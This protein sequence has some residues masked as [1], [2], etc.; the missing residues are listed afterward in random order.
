MQLTDISA[1]VL[2]P[3]SATAL[4]ALKELLTLPMLA[5]VP[6][7]PDKFTTERS[8]EISTQLVISQSV[9]G[10][11]FVTDNVA[12]M[13][14]VWNFSGYIKGIP[15]IELT[16]WFMPSLLAQKTVIDMAYKSR[17]AI[18]FRTTDGEVVA[19]LIK[20][21]RFVEEPDNM[22]TVRI[23]A[24]VQ[25]F[26]VMTVATSVEIS[27]ITQEGISKSL[28]AAGSTYGLPLAIGGVLVT[29]TVN[30][31]A[32]AVED[33]VAWLEADGKVNPLNTNMLDRLKSVLVVW[34][35]EPNAGIQYFEFYTVISLGTLYLKFI[36]DSGSL[37]W[38]GSSQL[39][40]DGEVRTFVLRPNIVI[41]SN[42]TDYSLQFRSEKDSIG[43]DDL[44]DM[45][46]DV[47]LW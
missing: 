44:A 9:G 27:S 10:K 18:P 1:S 19:V 24:D 20:R 5:G 34:F 30:V 13:P 46:M 45:E 29:N 21:L 14:R 26:N 23:E 43:L 6:I 25:E 38:T 11:E 22:N 2:I 32:Q 39:G 33:T 17:V 28:P 4:R 36:W 42:T 41:Y 37:E 35:L 16:N 7:W 40:L 3:S 47:L 12:P 31:V 8:A 15:F